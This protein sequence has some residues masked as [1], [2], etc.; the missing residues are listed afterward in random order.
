MK[1]NNFNLNELKGKSKEELLN[2]LSSDDKAKLNS[3]L[4]DK[5]SLEKLLKSPE[6][7]AIMK[8]LKGGKN[9]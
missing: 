4:N 2:S 7:L 1:N 8:M 5:A 9:G 6:A 3:I